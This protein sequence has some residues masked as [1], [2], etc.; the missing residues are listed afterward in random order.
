MN[1]PTWPPTCIG[2]VACA[3][4]LLLSPTDF[5]HTTTQVDPLR[6]FLSVYLANPNLGVDE[7]TRYLPI[8]VK[9]SDRGSEQILAY[10]TGRSWCGSGGCTLLVLER[11]GDFYRV[12]SRVT[13]ARPPLI[14]FDRKTNGWHNIGVFVEGGG[15]DSGYEAELEY[16]GASYPSN[17]SIP[18][19]KRSCPHERGRIVAPINAVGALLY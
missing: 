19:A 5:A 12:V 15:I 3:T 7:T 18:P 16:D 10:V 2:L 17:P 9:L 13:I 8:S 4:A 11:D 14:V 1:R 6:R